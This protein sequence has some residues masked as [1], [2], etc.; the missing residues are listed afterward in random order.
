MGPNHYTN[1][2]CEC[3]FEGSLHIGDVLEEPDT[4]VVCPLCQSEELLAQW[5]P[6]FPVLSGP[7]TARE[8]IRDCLRWHEAHWE[9]IR[10]RAK[11]TPQEKSA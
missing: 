11:K 10:R 7:F 5:G 8:A 6:F 2:W 1:I 4:K 3:G 9:N